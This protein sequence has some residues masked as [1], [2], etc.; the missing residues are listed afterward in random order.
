[1]K[2]FLLTT[3]SQ[4]PEYY[5]LI[6]NKI[7]YLLKKNFEIVMVCQKKDKKKNYKIKKIIFMRKI[8]IILKI[9]F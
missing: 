4:N 3:W 7:N 6:E 2:K 1:M 5:F 8:F 9:I